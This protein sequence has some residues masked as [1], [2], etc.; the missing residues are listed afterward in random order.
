MMLNTT[1]LV[2]AVLVP[3]I[4]TTPIIAIAIVLLAKA[5][6]AILHMIIGVMVALGKIHKDIIMLALIAAAMEDLRIIATDG[7]MTGA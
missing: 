6:V 4:K 7:P 2:R 1:K 5:H 3:A